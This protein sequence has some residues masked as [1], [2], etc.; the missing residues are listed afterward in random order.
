MANT[1]R[2]FPFEEGGSPEAAD[3]IER[4]LVGETVDAIEFE[5]GE[6]SAV[7]EALDSLT[8]VPQQTAMRDLFKALVLDIRREL[9][10]RGIAP[11]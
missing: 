1:V 7:C 2:A 6:R 11:P 5:T 10:S 8:L 3:K 4:F 9:R